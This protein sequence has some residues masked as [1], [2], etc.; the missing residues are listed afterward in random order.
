MADI[1]YPGATPEA[2][3]GLTRLP[4][5]VDFSIWQGDFQEFYVRLTNQDASPIDL[6][7][8]TAEAVLKATFDAVTEYDFECTIQGVDN[9]EIKVYM[10]SAVVDT[11]PAGSYIWN[12]QVTN[13]D[14]DV[15]TLLAGDVTVLA[16]VD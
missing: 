1:I 13:P 16:Q 7:G 14:G 8:Y 11:I 3:I 5:N 10:S 15:R 9:N 4:E 2:D 12:L 6:D